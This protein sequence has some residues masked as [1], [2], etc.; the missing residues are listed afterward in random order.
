MLQ[1][2]TGIPLQVCLCYLYNFTL[3][4]SLFLDCSFP[5]VPQLWPTDT[6][7]LARIQLEEIKYKTPQKYSFVI[8]NW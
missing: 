6:G 7:F 1:I 5:I 3:V 8:L 4:S 2:L